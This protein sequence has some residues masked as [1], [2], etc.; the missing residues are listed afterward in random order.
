MRDAD[1]DGRADGVLLT[2]SEKIGHAKDTKKPFPLAV[3]GYTVTSVGKATGKRILVTLKER[4][5]PDFAARPRVTYKRTTS[6]PVRDRAGNQAKSQRFAKASPHGVI[7]DEDGD[8]HLYPGDCAP[9][10]PAIHPGAADLPDL[11]FADTNCDGIDGD[12]S[13]AVFVSPLGN[14]GASGLLP[15]APMRTVTAALDAAQVSGRTAVL[16]A[17]GSYEEGTGIVLRAGIGVYGGYEGAQWSRSLVNAT[18]IHGS[19]QGAIASGVAGVALQLLTLSG[20]TA[21]GSAY[22]LRAAG[23]QVS[24]VA[25]TLEAGAGSPGADGVGYVQPAASGTVGQ[26]G[27]AGFEDDSYIYCAGDQTDP[28]LFTA[29]GTNAQDSTANGG[30]GGRGA[31]TN[32]ANAAGSS[33]Q[34]SPGG[35]LGGPGVSGMAG[36]DGGDGSPG[37]NGAAGAAG[38]SGYGAGGYAPVTGGTGGAGVRGQ[39][40]GGGAGGGSTHSTGTCN[41]WGGGGGG[42][43]AGGAGGAAGN[44]GGGG[45]GSFA[46]YAWGST[47]T[48]AGSTLTTG[49]A[50][51]GGAG[52]LGQTGGGGA[53]GGPGG[54]GYDEGKAGGGGGDGAKGGNGG[55]GGGGSGGP[56]IGIVS[57]GGAI[58]TSS[59][60]TFHIGSGGSG[61]APNGPAGAAANTLDL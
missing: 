5:A 41:D 28:P 40:G 8:R 16:V 24:L 34:P 22:G 60:L 38:S 53:A 3:A 59:M 31:I 26:T 15:A 57:G 13:K 9:N 55:I 36:S 10:D 50:G 56:S 39:G 47:V 29:P 21:G 18:V 45:G 44:G 46:L 14:D 61:G 20:T 11:A 35:A 12:L 37:G 2:F 25:V 51:A 27:A 23:S 19:P 52:S 33:G 54:A 7:A 1:R 30:Q 43:G 32:G 17:G 49:A 4:A 6:Q 42:G 58:V 48:I